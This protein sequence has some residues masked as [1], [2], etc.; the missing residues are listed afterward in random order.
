[1]GTGSLSG[2]LALTTPQSNAKVKERVELYINSPAE[3][4]EWTRGTGMLGVC[5]VKNG[6]TQKRT[7]K[8]MF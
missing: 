7:P 6:E 4:L 3:I 5:R 2:G 8:Q 1:V